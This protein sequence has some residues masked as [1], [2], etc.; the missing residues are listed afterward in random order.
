[1]IKIITVDIADMKIARQ[2]E[3][4]ITHALGSCVGICIYDPAVKIAALIHIMLPKTL[5]NNEPQIYKF[6]DT[7]IRETLKKL[8][9][10]GGSKRRFRC[11]I[12]GG[13]KMFATLDSS[14]LGNIGQRNIESVQGILMREQIPI[15]AREVGG[16]IARTMIVDVATGNVKIRTIGRP[17]INI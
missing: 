1:M 14:N 7:G 16:G 8:E 12:A 3:T 17:E 2:G 9:M 10:M 13:A 15:V 6:A 11:K 5:R 4:L